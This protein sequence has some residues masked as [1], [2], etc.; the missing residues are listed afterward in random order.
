MFEHSLDMFVVT[1]ATL[2]H[3][4]NRHVVILIYE[5]IF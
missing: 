1:P 3:R 4:V 5:L 2:V